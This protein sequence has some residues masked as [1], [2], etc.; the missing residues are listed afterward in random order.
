MRKSLR[1]VFFF[2]FAPDAGGTSKACVHFEAAHVVWEPTQ[3]PAPCCLV[4]STLSRAQ[5]PHL[6]TTLQKFDLLQEGKTAL[7]WAKEKGHKKIAQMIAEHVQVR[8]ELVLC[9][10][11]TRF[12]P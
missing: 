5:S 1:K 10:I 7:E 3:P 4:P 9:G 6:S 8:L 12:R 2:C 11:F